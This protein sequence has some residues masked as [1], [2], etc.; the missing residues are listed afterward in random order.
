MIRRP[1][2]STRT[3]TLFPYTTLFRSRIEPDGFPYANS[4]DAIRPADVAAVDRQARARLVR[5]GAHVDAAIG[6]V[7]IALAGQVQHRHV[8]PPRRLIEIIGVLL[9]L[10]VEADRKST[11]LNSSH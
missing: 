7:G 1:P 5:I 8:G 3:D 11:R 6:A 2:R 10:A 4:V 9:H